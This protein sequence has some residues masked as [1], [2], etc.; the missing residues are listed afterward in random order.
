MN[1]ILHY[2]P[3]I[4]I[5]SCSKKR[6]RSTGIDHNPAELVKAGGGKKICSDNHKLINSIRNKEELCEKWKESIIVP[7]YKKGD[8]TTCNNYRGISLLSSTYTILSNV[9]PSRLTPY[10]EEITGGH[11]CRFC[12]K[13]QPLITDS[14]FAKY[15]RKNGNT[16]KQC[17]SYL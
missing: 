4:F 15:F 10:A 5:N 2:I 11:Q 14:A 12:V 7:T 6:H 13:G 9:L 8:K 17:I 3:K 1:K 16:M